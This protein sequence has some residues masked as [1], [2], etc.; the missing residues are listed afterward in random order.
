VCLIC[1]ESV[2]HPNK[3][4]HLRNRHITKLIEDV[5]RDYVQRVVGSIRMCIF[6]DSDYLPCKH[7]EKHIK[8]RHLKDYIKMSVGSYFDRKS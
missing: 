6:C 5:R 3:Q 4:S 8:E 7:T 2:S 1:D